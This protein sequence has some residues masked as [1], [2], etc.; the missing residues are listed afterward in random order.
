MVL[1]YVGDALFWALAAY[2]TFEAARKLIFSRSKH[3][4]SKNLIARI[5]LR[6]TI[7]GYS[8]SSSPLSKKNEI[9]PDSVETLVERALKSKVKGFIFDIDSG[10]GSPVPSAEISDYIKSLDKPTV[11]LVRGAAASGAYMIASACDTII[12]NESSMVGSIGVTAAHLNFSEALGKYGIKYR[13]LKAGSH[14][15]LL[16]PLKAPDAE[17]DEIFQKYLDVLHGQFKE[18]VAKNRGMDTIEINSI[19]EGL[20]YIGQDAINK[21]LVDKI[22]GVEDAKTYIEEKGNFNKGKVIDYKPTRTFSIFNFGNFASEMGSE[23]ASGMME[24][25]TSYNNNR[26]P[27]IK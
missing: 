23:F 3:P 18:M 2:G 27:D 9:T 5:Y 25:L 26:T 21:K 24:K 11:A 6:G 19:S 22:G 7:R 14:K 17:E 4:I 20:I 10:G 8:S 12:A 13:S 16:S 15:D 1:G